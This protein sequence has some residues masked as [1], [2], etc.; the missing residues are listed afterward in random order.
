LSY[1][2]PTVTT[3]GD[4]ACDVAIHDNRNESS[5]KTEEDEQ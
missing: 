1:K 5:I 2:L 4:I 3:N